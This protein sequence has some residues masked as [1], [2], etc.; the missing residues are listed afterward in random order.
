MK[1]LVFEFATSTGLEDPSITAEGHAMLYS[2]LEDLKD[3]ETHHLV[4]PGW[5]TAHNCQSTPI[6]NNGNLNKWLDCNIASYDAC[7]PIAP[8]E[9]NLLHDLTII[10]EKQNVEVIGSS[11]NA[12]RLTTNKFDMYNALKDEIPVINTKQVFF[13]DSSQETRTYE[14]DHR[15]LFN[16]GVSKVLKPADGVSCSGVMVVNSLDEF[17]RAHDHI[18]EK[19]HLPY[20]IIQDYILGV[21]VSVSLLSD[22]ETAFPLSLNYQDVNLYSGEINYSGGKVPFKHILSE[23]AMETAKNAVEAVNGLKGYVGVDMILNEGWDE[24]HVVEINP[25]LTTPYVALRNIINFNLGEAVINSIHGELPSE[26]ILDGNVNFYK[27]G[28]NL[29]ISVLQ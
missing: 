9:D 19:T 13:R 6:V 11:S 22:G 1:I 18:K 3:Y 16:N 14:D 24:V 15:Y 12:V 23:R 25:R 21:N 29:R 7:L 10:I 26:V 5:E 20:F 28:K 4:S 27:E 17:M 8:E 2:L